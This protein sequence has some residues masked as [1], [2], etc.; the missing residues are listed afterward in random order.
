[1]S[2]FRREQEAVERMLSELEAVPLR[3]DPA[4][5]EAVA[6]FRPR[7]E[8]ALRALDNLRTECGVLSEEQRRRWGALRDLRRALD[9][10]M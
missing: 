10:M 1:M 6:R 8:E 9:N 4:F 5:R 2:T 7:L 3:P